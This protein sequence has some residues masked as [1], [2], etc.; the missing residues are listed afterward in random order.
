MNNLSTILESTYSTAKICD[1]KEDPKT[2]VPS[3]DLD[4]GKLPKTKE[5]GK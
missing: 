1:F 3:L 5:M 2:C 4:P